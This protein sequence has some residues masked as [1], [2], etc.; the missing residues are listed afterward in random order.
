MG[1]RRDS[2]SKGFLPYG[3]GIHLHVTSAKVAGRKQWCFLVLERQ[4]FSS[5]SS[6]VLAYGRFHRG[7]VFLEAGLLSRNLVRAVTKQYRRLKDA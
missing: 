2:G 3:N 4:L 6:V 7:R 1:V 5:K